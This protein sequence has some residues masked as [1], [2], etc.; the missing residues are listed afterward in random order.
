MLSCKV[1]EGI[2]IEKI[3]SLVH[4]VWPHDPDLVT[5]TQLR[6]N[7]EKHKAAQ[8]LLIKDDEEI[9]ASLGLFPLEMKVGNEVLS[10]YSIGAVHTPREYRRRGYGTKLLSF[11][12]DLM[13]K[14][15]RYV[16]LLYSDI[17][18]RFYEKHGFR[19]LQSFAFK[20]ERQVASSINDAGSVKV[21]E[22]LWSETA[23]HIQ[24]L[25]ENWLDHQGGGLFRNT[26]Y[27]GWYLKRYPSCRYF[28]LRQGKIDIGYLAVNIEDSKV[29][30]IDFICLSSKI[31]AKEVFAS[32]LSMTNG[33]KLVTGWWP[34][35]LEKSSGV[36]IVERTE[37]M[38]MVRLATDLANK[39]IDFQ[40][41]DHV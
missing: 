20:Y 2:E 6:L 29:V 26:S 17:D 38:P 30:V 21:S 8:W 13:E 7:S 28:M 37:E 19:H 33:P 31:N 10:G 5:H 25:Y 40:Q 11:A 36:E 15:N 27:W 34:L 39:N 18:P 24:K 4:E 1:A 14:Q 22:V 9:V 35:G 3:F 12:I 23:D 16:G 32:I 41:A